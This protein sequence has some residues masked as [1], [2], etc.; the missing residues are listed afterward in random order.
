MATIRLKKMQRDVTRI[1]GDYP[2][3]NKPIG[4]YKNNPVN[5]QG[6]KIDYDRLERIQ[7]KVAKEQSN[8]PIY[9]NTDRI[10]RP[11]PKGAVPQLT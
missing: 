9:L 1:T 11:L 10:D 5:T 3:S 7:R 4:P 2:S 6:D 8:R